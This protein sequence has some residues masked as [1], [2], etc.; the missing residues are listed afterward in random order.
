[1]T[2]TPVDTGPLATERPRGWRDAWT[3]KRVRLS[4]FAAIVLSWLLALGMPYGGWFDFPAF[5]AAGGLAFTSGVIDLEAIS[6]FQVEHG[7]AVGP[8]VYPAGVALF[9]APFA[10]LPFG[11]AGLLHF[12]LMAALLL[13]AVFTWATLSPLPRRWLI[14]GALAWSPAALGVIAGQNTSLALLLVV[15]TAWA[16][17]HERDGL[18]GMASGLLAYKPQLAAPMV[19]LLLLRGRWSGL[20]VA[21][22]FLGV[23][24]LLGV[25]ATGGQLD[26]PLPWLDNVDAYQEADFLVNGM[27]AISLPSFGRQ[28]ELLTGLPGL[29]VAGYV[30]AAVIVIVC[31][32]ALRRL[33]ASEAVALAAACGLLISPHAW[34]Y[35]AALLLPAVA[36]FATRAAARGWR[37]QDR[38]WL[39]LAYI[40]AVAWPLTLPLGF[41][42]L[43]VL[44]VATPF[45][46]LEWGP[47]RVPTTGTAREA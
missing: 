21:V 24:W 2:S 40:I 42:L 6:Q 16:L 37:W 32:P 10:A 4:L 41:T 43:P 15:S 13:L 36:V 5:Y 17:T 11:V 28:L 30:V 20:F 1:V 27:K 9:Y 39:A 22:L 7:L 29:M 35:D 14:V 47:F 23:H 46:L 44:L 38:W 33:P 3:P 31:I 26:W 34:A 12:L 19:G 45:A 8:W 25:V 18:A